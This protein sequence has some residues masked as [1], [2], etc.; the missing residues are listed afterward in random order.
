MPA[1]RYYPILDIV[2]ARD[3]LLR[4]TCSDEQTRGNIRVHLTGRNIA[5]LQAFA[6]RHR[7]IRE[8]YV[9]CLLAGVVSSRFDWKRNPDI[10]EG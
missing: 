9:L 6:V 4:M 5:N 2:W 10:Q 1:C 7:V 3:L 8:M